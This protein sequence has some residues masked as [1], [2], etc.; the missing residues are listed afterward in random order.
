[1]N[2]PQ[3]TVGGALRGIVSSILFQLLQRSIT[4]ISNVI[5]VRSVGEEITGFF[6]IHLQLL[7]NIVYFLSREFSRRIIMRKYTNDLSKGISFSLITIIVGIIINII[8]FPIL[9]Y[10]APKI[11]YTLIS[12]FIH[13]TGLF[14]ELIQEP[15]LVYMLLTQ[16]HI[17]R[18][19]CELPSIFIRMI[20]QA[21]LISL[22]PKYALII[23]PTLFALSSL[24]I[25]IF[26]YHLIKLPQI[27]IQM[28]SFKSLKLHSDNLWLFGRQTI[29]KFL[30]QE[31]EK[32]VLI[33]TTTLTIQGIFSVIS[34]I[35]SLVV[36]FL[37]LPIENISYSLFSKI[38]QNK[39]EL[40]NAFCSILK[41]IIHLSLLILVFGPPYSKAI[42]DFLYKN[43]EFTNNSY[44]LIISFITI[45]T[46]AING[47]SESFFHATATDK[48]LN[49]S[50]NLMFLF[51]IIYVSLCIILSK[52][53]GPSGLFIS[54]IFSMLLRTFYSY[55]NIYHLYGN[56][57]WKKCIPTKLTLLS[58]FLIF[59]INIYISFIFSTQS[60]LCLI[61]GICLGFIELLIIWLCDKPFIK[62]LKMFW[63]ERK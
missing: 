30:L 9:Y 3:Q 61:L 38:R 11:K 26:Y 13:S 56:L 52:L 24:I 62:S 47:I 6:H 31:G 15:Y 8:A 63:N 55:Y 44:L 59:I 29:Q 33:I 28:I 23:Q 20:L 37:F 46:I 42:L 57:P 22:Y 45:S 2:S 19:Y 7:M 14:L 53:F 41:I 50:N 16:K 32:A 51:S 4:F 43:N 27:N 54:N 1:M 21:I 40:I 60:F 17:F 25:F 48:Q 34:N 39:N 12:Y 58:L 18:I 35:S 5:V 10:Q 36:R 49:T